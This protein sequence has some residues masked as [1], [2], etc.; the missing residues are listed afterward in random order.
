TAPGRATSSG[1]WASPG[2][3]VLATPARGRALRD[4]PVSRGVLRVGVGGV[5]GG[6]RDAPADPSRDASH[7]SPAAGGPEAET[8]RP[9]GRETGP[10]SGW[11]LLAP[12]RGT[13][14]G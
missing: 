2:P 7:H 3:G 12:D 11:A 1:P 5:G 4:R 9:A 8:G 6:H 10:R 14:G 13:P